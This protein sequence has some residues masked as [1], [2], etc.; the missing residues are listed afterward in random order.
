MKLII[1]LVLMCLLFACSEKEKNN[2]P[3]I[4]VIFTDDQTY[5]AIG[6]NNTEIK[7]PVLDELAAEG[8]IFQNNYTATP[9]CA[10]S[11]ASMMTGLF[12]QQNETVGLIRVHLSGM[13]VRIRGIRPLQESLTMP[14]TIPGSVENHT[15]VLLKDMAFKE[16]KSPRVQRTV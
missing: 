11:R 4:V 9:I 1:S 12:P 10:A 15:W 5:N 13:Y 14:D 7:T 2:P 8:I 16:V 3:N 6:Y